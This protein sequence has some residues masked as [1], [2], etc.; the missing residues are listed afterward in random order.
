VSSELRVKSVQVELRGP[1]MVADVYQCPNTKVMMAYVADKHR[2]LWFTLTQPEVE[3]MLKVMKEGCSA[4]EL[5][6][7]V[8][9][10]DV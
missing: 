3:L 8:V 10:W 4:E 9:V 2:S 7:K 5:K 1:Q 6:D